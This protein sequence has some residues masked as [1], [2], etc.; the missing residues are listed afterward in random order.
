MYTMN[1]A[2]G[3]SPA[4]TDD[5]H[6][7]LALT[8]CAIEATNV[9][10]W[11]LE[12]GA[13]EPP[14]IGGTL[15]RNAYE[16]DVVGNLHRIGQRYW[17]QRGEAAVWER[18]FLTGARGRPP[19]VDIALFNQAGNKETRLE[20]GLYGSATSPLSKA[21]LNTD[22]KGLVKH[23]GDKA[24]GYPNVENYMLHWYQVRGRGMRFAMTADRKMELRD[25][26][27]VHAKDVTTAANGAYTVDFLRCVGG[28]LHSPVQEHH[29][30]TVALFKLTV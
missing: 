30:A 3:R 14:N 24:N 22:I 23:A 18:P 2:R 6:E 7:L 1:P 19:A 26:F 9:E 11:G 21:K 27:R 17:L 25:I 20:F 29:W 4:L 12:F 15:R 5:L 16:T 10:R 13:P 28:P 8:Y